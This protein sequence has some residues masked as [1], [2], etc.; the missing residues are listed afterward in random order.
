VL[1]YGQ[2]LHFTQEAQAVV[3]YLRLNNYQ[4]PD[5]QSSMKQASEIKLL[6]AQ[7]TSAGWC[8]TVGDR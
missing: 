2:M 7:A 4:V 8:T 1:T 5:Q 3:S 6:V